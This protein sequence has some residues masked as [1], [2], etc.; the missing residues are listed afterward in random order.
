MSSPKS[1]ARPRRVASPRGNRGA[2]RIQAVATDGS[3]SGGV[4]QFLYPGSQDGTQRGWRPEVGRDIARLVTQFRHRAMVSDG[5]YIYTSSGQVRGAVKEKADYT[6]GS[7]W[8]PVYLGADKAFADAFNATMA[9]WTENCDLRGRPFSLARNAHIACKSFDT[10][11]DF[12]I[13]LTQNEA[14][15]PRLQFLEAHRVGSP[16]GETL[17]P[18]DVRLP[19]GR[20]LK[21]GSIFLNGIV[22]DDYMRPLAYNLVQPD[23]FLLPYSARV[24]DQYQFLPAEAVIHGFDPE[25]YSQGRGIPSL[26]YG[27]LDWYDL[28]EIR[29]A[30]KIAT[31]ATARVAMIESNESGRAGLP[32]AH[33]A[34]GSGVTSIDDI[35]TR[36]K[37]ISAGL[38]RYFKANAGHKL[39]AFQ[40]ERP[41]RDLAD[42]LDHIARSAHRGLGWPIDMHDMSKIGGAAVRSVM[43]QIQRS[44]AQ[45]Q[46]AL[47]TPLLSAVLY[48]TGAFLGT[49]AL[50]FTRDWWNLGFTLPSKPSV[51]IGRDSQN[52]RADVAMGLRSLSEIAEEDGST[53]EELLRR[54]ANDWLLR[55]RIATETGVPPTA[56]FNPDVEVGQPMEP[57]VTLNDPNA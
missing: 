51:D 14:G 16:N 39:E 5:R 9:R 55:E 35:D 42:F 33:L 28:S 3:N 56:I 34:A 13:L 21:A 27:I 52:R 50:P 20:L 49:G 46:D 30:E 45:R 48:A 29:E 7:A 12:F 6:I 23:A 17:L 25:W 41:N 36:N 19:N 26:I 10:D 44:V 57:Q 24:R 53:A 32:N 47:W 8:R 1:A 22:Y 18:L 31:K 11:G 43:G 15:E 40:P 2:G 38:I 4:G 54:R 37:V